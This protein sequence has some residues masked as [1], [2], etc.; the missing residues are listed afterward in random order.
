MSVSQRE[1]QG[2]GC[3]PGGGKSRSTQHENA[4]CSPRPEP[5]SAWETAG[6]KARASA[7]RRP[8]RLRP[9]AEFHSLSL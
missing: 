7:G 6:D 8:R 1:G 9:G 4:C 3:T 5:D 2:A